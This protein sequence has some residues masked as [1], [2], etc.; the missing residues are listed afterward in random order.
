M[1]IHHKA[2]CFTLI[3]DVLPSNFLFSHWTKKWS[4]SLRI[5]LLNVNISTEIYVFV[6]STKNILTE[7]LHFLPNVLRLLR[8]EYFYDICQ[9][10]LKMFLIYKPLNWFIGL[11]WLV[12]VHWIC[13]WLI[14]LFPVHPIFNPWKHQKTLRF[15]DVFRG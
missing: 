4:F 11:Y 1:K 14:H 7:R 8:C 6:H 12:S 13:A 3:W 15:S 9:I 10:K 2:I 5:F